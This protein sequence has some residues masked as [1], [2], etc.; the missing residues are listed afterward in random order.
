MRPNRIEGTRPHPLILVDTI[1][2]GGTGKGVLQL[3]RGLRARGV[4]VTLANFRYRGRPSAFSAAA[5]EAGLDLVEVEQAHRLDTR[6]IGMLAAEARAR[7]CNLLE[8]HSF[9]AHVV[10]WRLRAALGLPWAAHAHGWTRES[11]RVLAYNALERR[12]LRRPEHVCVVS[13]QL[14]AELRAARSAGTLTVLR[15]GIEPSARALSEAERRAA[16]KACGVPERVC[17]I[18]AIGRLSREK[19][20]DVLVEALA[21]APATARELHVRVAGQGPEKA[22]IAALAAA[23]G[24]GDRLRLIGQVADVRTLMAASDAVVLPSRSEG[25][26]NVALEALDAGVPLVATHVGTLPEMIE[27]GVTGWL[28]PRESPEALSLAISQVA[29]LERAALVEMATRARH[30]ILPRFSA[31]RRVDRVLEI[32]EELLCGREPGRRGRR[33][34]DGLA[35]A[36]EPASR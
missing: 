4:P 30:A 11:R 22:H 7:G 15:N 6:V 1:E 5:R 25:V 20:L 17:M 14:E 10:A 19:G 3:A 2:I 18:A 28:V 13:P 24:L 33:L 12:L 9:K 36:P 16:R 31:A 29:A 26:P 27:D 8:S 34:D 21:R 35:P 32:Y 23:R